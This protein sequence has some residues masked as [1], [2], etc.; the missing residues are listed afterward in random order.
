M[1]S[2]GGQGGIER[3]AIGVGEEVEV[4]LPENGTTGYVWSVVS[5]G[6]GVQ[7][8]DDNVDLGQ[9]DGEGRTAPG[10][11]GVRVLRFRA[12]AAGTW[13]VTTRLA[14]PWEPGPL[15]ERRLAFAVS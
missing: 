3:Y 10:A 7:L 4:R 8:V 13:E 12:T 2:T 9:G 5:A 15:E 1:T 14:R 11:G 6:S